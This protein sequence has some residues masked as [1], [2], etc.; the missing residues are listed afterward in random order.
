[1]TRTSTLSWATRI[2]E[3][4]EH[5]TLF[6]Y[7]MKGRRSGDENVSIDVFGGYTISI[8]V[9][10]KERGILLEDEKVFLKLWNSLAWGHVPYFIAARGEL[11]YS[12]AGITRWGSFELFRGRR[13]TPADR[14]LRILYSKRVVE[15]YSGASPFEDRHNV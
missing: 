8:E 12:E 13:S 6:E 7:A 3:A 5:W 9:Y 11:K 15:L 1:M 14:G 10:A 2:R 4:K